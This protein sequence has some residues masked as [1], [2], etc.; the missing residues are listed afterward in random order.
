MLVSSSDTRV[1]LMYLF[2][3]TNTARRELVCNMNAENT[4]QQLTL[5]AS[6]PWFT[7]VQ[8]IPFLILNGTGV[9]S[10]FRGM[11]V[12]FLCHCERWQVFCVNVLHF[13][14]VFCNRRV[15]RW[16]YHGT[17]FISYLFIT[18]ISL[19][20]YLCNLMFWIILSR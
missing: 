20:L 19:N 14:K 6:L 11:K 15:K 4:Q 3:F 16:K 5:L 9:E 18:L 7:R 2:L 1:T 10:T 8:I 12:H 17:F 13:R